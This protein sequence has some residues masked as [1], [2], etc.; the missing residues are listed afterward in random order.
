MALRAQ[1]PYRFLWSVVAFASGIA[2]YMSFPVE[3]PVGLL[4][5]VVLL[6][7]N[8]AVLL[9]RYR[10]F[11]WAVLGL[12]CIAFGCFWA[13]WHTARPPVTVLEKSMPPRTVTGVIAS[14]EFLPMGQRITLEGVTIGYPA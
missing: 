14:V 13:G 7:V 1:R 10:R 11:V 4:A 12:A 3:P 8:A 9:R 5:L 6:L 2:L